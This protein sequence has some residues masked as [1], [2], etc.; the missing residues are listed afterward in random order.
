ML[1]KYTAFSSIMSASEARKTCLSEIHRRS[2]VTAVFSL[3]LVVL[4]MNI[5]I[6]SLELFGVF[7]VEVDPP[8]SR[9]PI[10]ARSR[11]HPIK[12]VATGRR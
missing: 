3:V 12:W 1:S 8:P 9:H 10:S 6:I 4:L 5:Q 7:I 11:R 2:D